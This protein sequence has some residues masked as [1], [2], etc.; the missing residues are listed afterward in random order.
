MTITGWS[1]VSISPKLFLYVYY[2]QVFVAVGIC[3]RMCL[4]IHCVNQ[5]I[6]MSPMTYVSRP[7]LPLWSNNSQ[8]FERC[9]LLLEVCNNS[10]PATALYEV[11][12]FFTIFIQIFP[13][14]SG[15]WSW[16]QRASPPANLFLSYLKLLYPWTNSALSSK[17]WIWH[18]QYV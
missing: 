7:I 2:L 12:H 10:Q 13:N 16:M 9:S 6:L 5:S 4:C 3:A 17:C 8:I 14:F 18:C 1:Y 11:Y 15:V